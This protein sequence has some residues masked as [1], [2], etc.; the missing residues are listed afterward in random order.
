[1]LPALPHALMTC[2]TPA[3]RCLNYRL[4]RACQSCNAIS[5]TRGAR[6]LSC[7]VATAAAKCSSQRPGRATATYQ[8][9]AAANKWQ[10]RC[11]I[12]VHPAAR[13]AHAATA[14]SLPD[15]PTAAQQ[16][17][18]DAAALAEELLHVDLRS[19]PHTL[20]A[21]VASTSPAGQADDSMH[22]GKL[23]RVCSVI[24]R[25]GSAHAAA[26]HTGGSDVAAA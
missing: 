4:Q 15:S 26:C 10:S 1:M 12:P 22:L 9:C 16:R 20:R 19:G 7:G 6:S 14:H 5:A 3:A 21:L 23:V 24:A 2:W 17:L 11:S 13:R 8:H 18:P 25:L